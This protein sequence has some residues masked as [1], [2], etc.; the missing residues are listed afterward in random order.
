MGATR[1]NRQHARV[2][3]VQSKALVTYIV[4]VETTT[5]FALYQVAVRMH[6]RAV[7][8]ELPGRAGR[9]LVVERQGSLSPLGS[10]PWTA[11]V[12]IH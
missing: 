6:L 12:R 4:V 11:R 5:W 10:L 8:L 2:A 9:Q 1:P 7:Q 3:Q